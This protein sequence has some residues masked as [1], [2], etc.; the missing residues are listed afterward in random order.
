MTRVLRIH[1]RLA[2][3]MHSLACRL[4]ENGDIIVPEYVTLIDKV[5]V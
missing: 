4:R 1:E 3:L 2:F 5:Q